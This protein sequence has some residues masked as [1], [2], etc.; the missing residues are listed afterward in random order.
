MQQ[1]GAEPQT[2]QET[3][4]RQLQ[5]PFTLV[6][7]IGLVKGGSQDVC[8]KQNSGKDACM[9]SRDSLRATSQVP[10]QVGSGGERQK[11]LQ[12]GDETSSPQNH[13][14]FMPLVGFSQVCTYVHRHIHTHT[15]T[16]S[17]TYIHT[18]ICSTYVHIHTYTY[19]HTYINCICSTC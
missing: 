11:R 1:K 9:P 4:A 3:G 2:P 10:N 8:W 14:L 6:A 5:R 19:S 12:L 13:G 18:C 16:C 7:D 17:H 15:Y